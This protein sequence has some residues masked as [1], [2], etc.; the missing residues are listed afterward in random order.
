MRFSHIIVVL[1]HFHR[2]LNLRKCRCLDL[3]KDYDI[4]I[5]SHPGK[6]NVVANNAR[7]HFIQY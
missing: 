2:D 1:Q 7:L 6:D 4:T 5:L 3:V